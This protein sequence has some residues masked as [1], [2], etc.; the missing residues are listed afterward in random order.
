MFEKILREHRIPYFISGGL[1][2][3]DRTEVKDVMAYLRLVANHD[4]DSAFLRIVNT[5]RRGIGPGTLEK[6]GKYA[7]EKDISLF[8][9][10]SHLALDSR[11]AGTQLASLRQFCHWIVNTQM[12]FIQQI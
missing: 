11:I 9:A 8:S 5:P 2:F 7:T 1:S 4:D 6:L 10:T 3:F 12:K